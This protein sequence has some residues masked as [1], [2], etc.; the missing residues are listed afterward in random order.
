MG[1]TAGSKADEIRVDFEILK[2]H[3]RLNYSDLY[4]FDIT[5]LGTKWQLNFTHHKT[6]PKTHFV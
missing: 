5:T 4:L 1:L 6:H 3:Y 2:L